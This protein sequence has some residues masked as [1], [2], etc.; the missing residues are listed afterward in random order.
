MKVC[1]VTQY[2]LTAGI[3]YD[4]HTHHQQVCAEGAYVYIDAQEKPTYWMNYA[5]KKNHRLS[6]F[7]LMFSAGI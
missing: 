3:Y 1:S 5:K 7:F 4:Y 2:S 6:I